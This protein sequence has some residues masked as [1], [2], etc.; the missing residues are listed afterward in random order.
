MSS[1]KGVQVYASGDYYI[2]DWKNGMSDGFGEYYHVKDKI[3]YEGEWHR[4]GHIVYGMEPFAVGAY[5]YGM[6]SL[7]SIQFL[8]Q[9]R[10]L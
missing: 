8:T 4:G 5:S 6:L 2:G 3:T 9:F 10:K 1:G 7:I